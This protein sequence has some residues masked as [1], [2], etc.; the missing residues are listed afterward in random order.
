MLSQAL[1]RGK[2]HGIHHAEHAVTTL[3]ASQTLTDNAPCIHP[4]DLKPG[5]RNAFGCQ[6][7]PSPS[8]SDLRASNDCH[9]T[10]LFLHADKGEPR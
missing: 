4:A 6:F 2:H 5:S 3:A 9:T 8:H 1:Q 10:A 7:V